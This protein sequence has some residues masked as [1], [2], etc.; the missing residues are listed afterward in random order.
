MCIDLK[1]T[2]PV[3]WW[4]SLAPFS[5]ICIFSL[6]LLREFFSGHWTQAV[7]EAAPALTFCIPSRVKQLS[8]KSYFGSQFWSYWS[9]TDWCPVHWACGKLVYHAGST[10]WRRLLFHVMC[11]YRERRDLH[12]P[13]HFGGHTPPQLT[14][15]KT[16]LLGP[17]SLTFPL[18]F[19]STEPKKS[20]KFHL[21]SGFW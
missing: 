12:S 1:I 16:S 6:K 9:M 10:Q 21:R 3:S 2:Q 15:P 20:G 17:N 8:V 7:L 5:S 13:T 18:P 14:W 19:N 11:G 4:D